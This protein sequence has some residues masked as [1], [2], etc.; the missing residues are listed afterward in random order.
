[1]DYTGIFI[2]NKK[3][4]RL[5]ASIEEIEA[6]NNRVR[7]NLISCNLNNCPC[8]AVA[9]EEF[10]RH[11]ARERQFYVI[12]EQ[13]IKVVI[14]L[15]LRW[16]CP[17]CGKTFTGYPEFALPYKRYTVSTILKFSAF[18]TEDE[19]ISYREV[20]KKMP[21]AYPDSEIQMGHS[22]IHRWITD[23][24]NS[25]EIIRNS[26][27]MILQADPLSSICRDIADLFVPSKKYR[28][29]E[30]YKL[31]FYC[32]Q[33]LIIQNLFRQN[34]KVQIFPNFETKHSFQ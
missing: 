32:R 31:L 10:K 17:G 20:N 14:G 8:C 19:Q 15:L 30:R 4:E 11:E 18:Y 3:N 21:V 29:P 16:K 24:G 25:T 22:T 23:I 26:I 34:F 28:T 33:F 5:S 6:Y 12:V 9:P 27:D 1:M 7:R 13:V 2:D